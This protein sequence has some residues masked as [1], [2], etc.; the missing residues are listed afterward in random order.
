MEKFFALPEEKQKN[1]RNAALQCFARYGY[2][3]TSVNDIAVAA[4]ISKA[5]VFQ[6]FGS[7]KQLYVYLLEYIWEIAV[8]FFDMEALDAI[9]DLFDRVLASGRMKTENLKKQPYFSAFAASVWE[10][11][12]PEVEEEIRVL[13]AHAGVF[14]SDLALRKEDERKFKRK[15]DAA[16]V[17]QMLLLMAEGYAARCRG[18]ENFDFGGVMDEF[19]KNVEILRRNFYKE[20]YLK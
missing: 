14:R 6:Y 4:H 16:P 3:K 1:I 20:E 8:S 5:S 13:K 17:F 15:E 7:K 12:A 18:A 2:E 10:E 11:T 9:P 19:E